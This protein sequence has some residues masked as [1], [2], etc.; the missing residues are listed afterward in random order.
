MSS[1]L[2][3]FARFPSAALLGFLCLALGCGGT[4]DGEARAG[5]A[6][7][8]G[9]AATARSSG[10]I[11]TPPRG[12][13]WVVFGADTVVAEVARSPEERSEGLMYREEVPPGTGMLFV[14]ESVQTRSFWMKNTYVPLSIAFIDENHRVVEIRDMEPEDEE[15]T[16]SSRPALF[17]LE[18]QQGWFQATGIEVGDQAEIVFGPR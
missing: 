18:V 6:G 2:P 4:A 11:P 16:R 12:R 5:G 13:A 17:A 15:F 10:Q 9:A 8:S 1:D 14:F 3:R 7:D